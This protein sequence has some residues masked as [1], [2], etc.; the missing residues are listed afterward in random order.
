MREGGRWEGKK[1]IQ[2][3]VIQIRS[4]FSGSSLANTANV[5]YLPRNSSQIGQEK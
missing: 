4:M 5:I 1:Y 3:E 2:R